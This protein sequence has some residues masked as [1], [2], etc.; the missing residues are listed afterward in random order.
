MQHTYAELDRIYRHL[1][2]LK[3]S[4]GPKANRRDRAVLMIGACILQGFDT[5]PLII[6]GLRATGLS[7]DNVVGILDEQTGDVPGVHLWGCDESGIY[8]VLDSG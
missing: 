2:G 8:R 5:R 1:R 4:L 3:E 6:K 7:V